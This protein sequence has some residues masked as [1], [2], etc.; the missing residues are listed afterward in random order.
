MFE[1]RANYVRC[2]AS[3][4]SIFLHYCPVT[5]CWL[6]QALSAS[7]CFFE[8]VYLR[9]RHLQLFSIYAR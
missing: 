5:L 1:T 8:R 2:P 3:A 9:T 6:R 4:V 7:I